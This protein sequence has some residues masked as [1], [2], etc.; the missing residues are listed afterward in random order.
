MKW[1]MAGADAVLLQ[2]VTGI[3]LNRKRPS[4]QTLQVS[5]YYEPISALFGKLRHT[6]STKQ[7]RV[8]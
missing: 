1:I 8:H 2:R 7:D 4:I 5:D 6:N 3:R